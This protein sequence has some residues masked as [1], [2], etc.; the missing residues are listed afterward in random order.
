MS[1]DK[2]A[3]AAAALLAVAAAGRGRGSAAKK[4]KKASPDRPIGFDNMSDPLEFSDLKKAQD[5][6][7]LVEIVDD[8]REE[9]KEEEGGSGHH[10][11][12]DGWFS[13]NIKAHILVPDWVYKFYNEGRIQW[14]I[15]DQARMGIEDLIEDMKDSGSHLFQEW[16]G[17][18]YEIRGAS[19]GYIGFRHGVEAILDDAAEIVENAEAGEIT[20]IS[21]A[22][23]KWIEKGPISEMLDRLN[24]ARYMLEQRDRLEA[25][26]KKRVSRYVEDLSSDEHWEDS[27]LSNEDATKEDIEEAK[28]SAAQGRG[29][30]G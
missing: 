21:I 17:D 11:F 19:G 30:W 12:G 3:L 25:E 13:F 7:G 6:D 16:Y 28:R 29:R 18:E 4:R 15:E 5:V 22:G 8:I 1:G 23:F 2:I 10:H 14:D 20:R 24:Q 27:I 9:V 26:I